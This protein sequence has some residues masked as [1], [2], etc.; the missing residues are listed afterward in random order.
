MDIYIKR[1]R[2]KILL[3][4]IAICIGVGSLWYTNWLTNKIEQEERNKIELWAKAIEG[5][6]DASIG[7]T[8]EE[9]S[10]LESKYLN[11][12]NLVTAQN[13]TIPIIILNADGS[14]NDDNNISYK[15]DRREAV[16]K[17]ELEKMKAFADPIP[18]VIDESETL[19]LYHRESS[20]LRNLKLYPIVQLVVILVFIAI[21]YFAFNATNRAEQN[22]VWVGMSK[23]TAH[24][25]G[26]PI[27]S[28]M[29]WI[30]LLKLKDVDR[31]LISELE[32]DTKRLER[33]TERFSKIG[34]KPELLQLNLV[35]V[36][37][38]SVDYLKRRSSNKVK[39]ELEH[40]NQTHIEVP[41]NAALFSWVIENL[42]K[43]AIDAMENRGTISIKLK[44][45]EEYVFIDINDT[46]IGVAKSHYKTVFQP[47]YST[48][49]RGWGLGLSL[50]KR[51]IEIYHSGKI[52]V[53][54]SE[55]KKGTTFRIV[56]N[57]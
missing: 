38:S 15:Q 44:E 33:I 51:I 13:K 25:L 54:T 28:L 30:E 39:F 21:S 32:Q 10:A 19:L 53:K 55:H 29:A 41:L 3:L 56:L 17:K 52:F 4:L 14:F 36:L 42:C 5:L 26:T 16:L 47:G 31:N 18:I 34:S 8:S 7:S 23:E 20:I 12:L 9:M 24:Q 37:N 40:N 1:R 11:F 43:N 50:A 2:W 35:E 49:K 48:K 22:Q 6:I 46:G 45:K 27:S 57:K